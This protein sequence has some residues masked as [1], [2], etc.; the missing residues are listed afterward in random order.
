MI[1][2]E[3]ERLILRDFQKTDA[4]GLFDYLS[5]PRVNCF[6]NE[7]INSLEEAIN[8]IEKRSNNELELAVCIKE[9]DKIIGNLFAHKEE[10]DTYSVGWNFNKKFEGKG[11][12][13]ESAKGLFDYIF[14]KQEARRIYCYVE[15]DN[16]RSQNLCK[17]L[18][19]RQEGVFI[20]FISF[21]KN[22]DDTP[23]YENTMQFAILKK[24]WE[25]KEL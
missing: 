24:E 20:E 19:M 3:T 18:G 15:E 1:R 14:S 25:Q 10:S 17:R 6:L 7:K 16:I 8:D 5:C 12:A 9:N 2:I 22:A 21:V 23:K 13:T 11:F 4:E